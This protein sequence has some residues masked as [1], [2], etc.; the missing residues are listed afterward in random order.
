MK[1]APLPRVLLAMRAVLVCFVLLPTTQAVNPPPGGGYPNGNTAVGGEALSSL[2]TGEDN[3]A[4]GFRALNENI[5]GN[6]NTAVGSTALRNNRGGHR[7]TATGNAAL[8]NNVSGI[9]NTADGVRALFSNIHGSGNTAVGSHALEDT[10]GNNNIALGDLAGVHLTTGN[11]NVDIGN[12]GF[13]GE[14]SVLRIGGANQIRTFIG[15]IFGTRVNDAFAVK[16]DAGGRLGTTPS[17][18]RFKDEIRPMGKVSEA[19]FALKPVTFRYKKELDPQGTLQFGLV[20]EEVEMVNPDLVVRDSGGKP[21]TVRYDA[22]NAMLLNEFLKEHR[23][24]AALESGVAQLTAGLKEQDSK[25]QKV[26]DQLELNQP[27]PQMVVS[28]Q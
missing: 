24:I 4:L 13:A 21:Y 7:N 27:A 12:D 2:T 14:N 15:G 5:Q 9:D 11:N 1:G 6:F 23:K 25:I 3:T 10:T 19:I 28:E 18:Q 8:Y 20:A 26:S 22:V 17:S 16:V